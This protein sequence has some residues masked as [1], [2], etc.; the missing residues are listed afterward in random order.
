[1]VKKRGEEYPKLIVAFYLGILV[2]Y[3]VVV[4]GIGIVSVCGFVLFSLLSSN[5]DGFQRKVP[6]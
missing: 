6:T 5:T 4:I 3:F 1:M 2:V